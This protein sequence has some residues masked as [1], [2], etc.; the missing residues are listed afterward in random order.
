[1]EKKGQSAIEFLM[2]YGWA[3]LIVVGL[4]AAL[5]LLGIFSGEI[6]TRCEIVGEFSCTDAMVGENTLIL[7]LKPGRVENAKIT[8]VDVNGESCSIETKEL[9]AK[10]NNLVKCT[11]LEL[12]VEEKIAIIFEVEYQKLDSTIVHTVE[13]SISGQTVEE[14]RV[15]K[16]L[17]EDE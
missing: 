9:V 5:W 7:N 1:M 4:I 3:V 14:S 15:Q 10:Q 6:P 16:E 2:S 17:G 11:G 8:S 13:G 12:E